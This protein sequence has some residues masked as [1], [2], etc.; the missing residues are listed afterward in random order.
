MSDQTVT[1]DVLVPVGITVR[2][3]A[4]QDDEDPISVEVNS[5]GKVTARATFIPGSAGEREAI[6]RLNAADLVFD[7]CAP[8]SVLIC[9]AL[10][11]TP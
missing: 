4:A 3:R 8:G 1:L 11:V 6:E 7:V 5:V 9:C 2:E 10:V